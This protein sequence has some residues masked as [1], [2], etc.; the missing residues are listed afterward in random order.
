MSDQRLLAVGVPN[1][2]A[3]KPGDAAP[4]ELGEMAKATCF[5]CGQVYELGMGHICTVLPVIRD[6]QKRVEEL[7]R[8]V[9]EILP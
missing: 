2:G 9:L 8:R 7:E 4:S 3:L 1:H 6:L 5:H